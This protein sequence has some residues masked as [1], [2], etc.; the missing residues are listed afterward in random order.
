MMRNADLTQK[1]MM[2]L[3][4][5]ADGESSG[6]DRMMAE[7]LLLE[8][9]DARAYLEAQA[10]L[11]VALRKSIAVDSPFNVADAVMT[12]VNT[13]SHIRDLGARV[14]PIGAAPRTDT[15]RTM[16]RRIGAAVVAGLALA[17]GAM[18]MISRAT[19]ELPTNAASAMGVEVEKMETPNQFHLFNVPAAQNAK[20]TSVVVWIDDNDVKGELS[21]PATAATAAVPAS[22]A[23]TAPS[24]SISSS[25]Q[26]SNP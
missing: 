22:A 16:R 7:R 8:K 4:A 21:V 3:M 2:L 24:A 25:P 12:S 20:A 23:T 13:S 1:E 14:V 19:I 5:Y 18:F 6:T 26:K 10:D 9:N 17:A 15:A 11:A